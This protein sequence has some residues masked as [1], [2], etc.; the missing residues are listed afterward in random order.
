C[1]SEKFLQN[2]NG[3]GNKWNNNGPWVDAG[4]KQRAGV[5]AA[6]ARPDF[7][8]YNLP[9]WPINKEQPAM[10]EMISAQEIDIVKL[11]ELL[12]QAKVSPPIVYR[13]KDHYTIFGRVPD[14]FS[15][16]EK[17]KRNFPT[18]QVKNY[19]DL[20]YEFNRSHCSDTSTAREWDHII[21]TAN[22]VADPKLQKEYLDYHATQFQKWPEMAKGFCNANFQQLLLFRNGR[23]LM[24]VI[25]IPKGESLDKLNPKTTENNPRVDEWNKIMKKYQEGIAGTAKGETWIFLEALK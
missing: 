11:K 13:W 20:F 10:I 12:V 5:E 24:L 1:P 4:I 7:V 21:L 3:P 22:L 18:A 2:A 8:G 15:L 9:Q 19:D 6:Y 16:K 23:Q 25:S 14:L 17:L